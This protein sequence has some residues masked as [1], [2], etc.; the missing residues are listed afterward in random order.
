M[1]VAYLCFLSNSL[2]IPVLPVVKVTRAWSTGTTSDGSRSSDE[3]LGS[4]S[5]P[6]LMWMGIELSEGMKYCGVC[7]CVCVWSVGMLFSLL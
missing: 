3:L 7:V 1:T 5:C 4:S 6:M 2:G